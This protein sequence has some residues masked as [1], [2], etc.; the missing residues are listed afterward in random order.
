[1]RYRLLLTV[2]TLVAGLTAGAGGQYDFSSVTITTTHVAGNVYMLEGSGGNIAVSVGEDGILMIDAQ[3]VGLAPKIEAALNELSKD[4]L[5]FL[6]NTHYHQDHTSGN[7]AFGDQ[8]PIFAHHN[9]RRRL[10]ED[11]QKGWPVVTFEEGLSIHFNGEEIKALHYPPAHTDGDVL[12]YFT[13]A[14]VVHI[15]DLIFSDRFP[16]V[17]LEAGGDVEGYLN[18]IKRLSTEL[19]P[20]ILLVS[21]HSPVMTVDYL[22]GYHA[23]LV[24]QVAFIRTGMDHGRTLE[25][26]LEQGLPTKWKEWTWSFVSEAAWIETVFKSYGH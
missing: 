2:L 15:G 11:P 13:G 1:M 12:V 9:V 21:G 20:D 10:A 25:Q 18:A 5:K 6:L 19:P 16:Y 7:P 22:E 26:L 4:D 17:D 8:A 14:K 23:A 24:E 3:F